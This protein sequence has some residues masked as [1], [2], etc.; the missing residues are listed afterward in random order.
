MPAISLAIP[1]DKL[2]GRKSGVFESIR[3]ENERHT[4]IET[5]AEKIIAKIYNNLSVLFVID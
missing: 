2:F 3:C 5:T 1:L 4:N